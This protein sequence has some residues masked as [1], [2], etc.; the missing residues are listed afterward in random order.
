MKEQKKGLLWFFL[1]Q[2]MFMFFS[3]AS[4]CSKLA[5]QSEPLSL[6]FFLLYGGVLLILGVYALLW[7]QM[8]KRIP[9]VTAYASKAV[10]VIWGLIWGRLFFGE[11]IT[12][13]KMLGAAIIICGIL[14]VV[15]S[16][17]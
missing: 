17:E 10:T 16:D 14:V 7:Q 3:L 9:L 12:A 2:A 1:L 11:S 8:L 4:V 6:R 15:K 13:L 5:A